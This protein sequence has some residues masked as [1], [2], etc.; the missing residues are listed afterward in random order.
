MPLTLVLGPANSAK[1]GE[2]LGAYALA[3]RRDALL[4]VPTA[5]DVAHY[6]RELAAP[7]VTLGRTLTFPRLIEEIALRARHRRAR[8]TPLQSE[9]VMR[10]AIA[11]LRL[12]PLAASAAGSGFARAAGRLIA[13][14]E[15]QRV[16]PA[17]F[18]SALRQWAGGAAP[19][20]DAYARE[21][22]AIYRRYQEELARL[23][24]ADAETFAWGALD[25]L[26]ERPAR[27]GATPVFFYG[28]DDLT[29]V[30]LDT[31]E[32]LSRQ[33][34][35]AVTV[36]L[37]YE[38]DR[39]ALAARA[40][41]V[42]ELRASAQSV[43]QLPALE[44][45]YAPAARAALHHLERHLFEADPP[46]IDPGDA[47][48]L[49]EAGGERAEAELVA[50]GVLAALGDGVPAEEIV[51]VCRSL[52]RSGE[53]FERELARHGVAGTSARR[54][55]LE[56][57][58]LGRALLALVR[59]A[60]LP[61]PQR[62]VADLIAYL[63]HPGL[64]EAADVLDR[65]EAEL[66]RSGTQRASGA[67]EPR[68]RVAPGPGR[69]RGAAPRAR[70]GGGA[71]GSCAPAAGRAIP[72]HGEAAVGRRAARRTCRHRGAERAGGAGA[73]RRGPG[74][75][76]DRVDRAAGGAARCPPTGRRRRTRC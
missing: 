5:A 31:I 43:S 61:A 17:R 20:R 46:V 75:A 3:A 41:V 16:T 37:T 30:E 76:G 8:L 68:A 12:G 11:S 9:Q 7:G 69:A 25:A 35:A 52:S 29:P 74:A 33:A 27:W 62:T 32:T 28:F 44:E 19:E 48:V 23:D 54:V 58:A 14:L 10:R 55:P 65:L 2:V 64:V 53:L 38:P 1:A 26:R 59:C 70:P 49:M 22:A 21:L 24:R 40:T 67:A 18:S 45:Y 60:L 6:E 34:E 42:E 63:R 47:V 39:P 4:V 51:V 66:R 72:R 73:A 13:E 36:S 71:P 15:Q 56:H 50:A 57:T